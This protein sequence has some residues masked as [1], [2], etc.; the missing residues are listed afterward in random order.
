M[1]TTQYNE[2]GEKE[3]NN[4]DFYEEVIN[5][6][7]K[8][9]KTQ[10]DILVQSMMQKSEIS[11]KVCTFLENGGCRLSNYY[12]LLKTHNIPHDLDNPCD[13]LEENGF[14]IRGIISGRG[15]P[16]ERLS[17]F[18][19]HFLQPGM[20]KLPTFLQDTKH[21]L[22][23][24][25]EVNQKIDSGEFS[26]EGVGVVS[27]DVDKMYNN[28]TEDLGVGACT[29]FLNG[30]VASVG[31]G[32]QE[33]LQVTTNSIL[34]ALDLCMKNNFFEFNGRIFKQTK[35][36]G[37]GLK[38]A[39]PYACLGLGKFENLVFDSNEECLEL[40]KLWKRY[41]DDILMLFKG[42]RQQLDELVEWLNSLMPGV[43][44]FKSNFSNKKIEFLDLIILIEDGKIETDLYIK[45]TNLQ[46]YL[47]YFSN[48][49][50]HCKVGIVYSQAI[51]IIERCS[52]IEYTESHLE[53]LK[54]K[55]IERNYPLE[56]IEEQF[57]RAQKKERKKLIYQKRKSQTKDDKVRLI[58]CHII[59]LGT[60]KKFRG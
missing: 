27:L 48:H 36:V 37:T 38:M 47:D 4:N 23:I 55:L 45:P 24:L 35:G 25:D 53:K 56:V 15:S 29:E 17:G 40:I 44:R 60:C 26:L 57:E 50:Q 39:P 12:H 11:E 14:P 28:M 46:L 18:V 3:L 9:V 31:G 8:N 7:S 2:A 58:C 51:R 59:Y 41:I 52:K 49:P 5:D 30:R 42:S 1:T 43:I 21:T 13:W 10:S 20:K 33:D 16:L 32:S 34:Q 54:N 19:D 22:Q 6:P